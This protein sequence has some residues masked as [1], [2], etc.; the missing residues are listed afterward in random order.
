MQIK[1]G[2]TLAVSTSSK[3]CNGFPVGTVLYSDYKFCN[4]NRYRS[5]SYHYNLLEIRYQC[6]ECVR[7]INPDD[8][9]N[10][11][12]DAYNYS[13]YEFRDKYAYWIDYTDINSI[14]EHLI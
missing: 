14:I 4:H 10:I 6:N 11:Y 13:L 8:I 5:L 7:I 2:L 3:C 1:E 9:I 12:Y